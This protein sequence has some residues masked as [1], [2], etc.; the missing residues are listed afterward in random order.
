MERRKKKIKM[1][2]RTRPTK[3]QQIEILWKQKGKCYWCEQKFGQALATKKRGRNKITILK[4]YYDH[5]IPFSYLQSNPIKNFVAACQFC[6]G[7]KHSKMF[8]SEAKCHVY[9]IKRWLLEIEK[10][11][12]EF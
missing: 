5:V 1:G 3:R 9:L 10:G 2:Y 4:P 6:N 11:R 7:W 12:I 8:N